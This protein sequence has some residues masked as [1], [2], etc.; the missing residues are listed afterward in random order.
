MAQSQYPT[1]HAPDLSATSARQGRLGPDVF[2]VLV[3]SVVFAIAALAA[4][5]IWRAPQL[6]ASEA[7]NGPQPAPAQ[8]YHVP[9]T[10]SAPKP[11]PW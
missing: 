2:W 10:Q 8:T 5:W 9:P 3:I 4:A 6:A 7:N 11:S 1:Q